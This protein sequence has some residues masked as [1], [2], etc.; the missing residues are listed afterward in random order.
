MWLHAVYRLEN[1]YKQY[2]ARG[3][4][5]SISLQPVRSAGTEL[6]EAIL[7]TYLWCRVPQFKKLKVN[8]EDADPLY[9]SSKE[10][11]GFRRL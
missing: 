4:R 7:Q 3:L 2:H 10:Q 9:K 5:F 8:G 6:D 11:K 1:L